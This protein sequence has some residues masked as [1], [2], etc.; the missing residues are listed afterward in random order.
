MLLKEVRYEVVKGEKT[1]NKL[2]FNV[3]VKE[4]GLYVVV[5]CRGVDSPVPVNL[6]EILEPY[7]NTKEVESLR[8]ITSSIFRKRL[9][10]AS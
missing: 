4:D 3:E 1:H 8:R 10:P 7:L 2:L 9:K 5:K 6:E